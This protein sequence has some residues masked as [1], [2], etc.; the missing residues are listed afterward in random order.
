MKLLNLELYERI[1]VKDAIVPT[2]C[3]GSVVDMPML[4]SLSMSL[5]GIREL[6]PG[7]FRNLPQLRTLALSVNNITGIPAGVFN[8]LGL[9]SLY[10]SANAI[11]EIAP[12]A[13]DD[14][15]SLSKL[16][17]DNNNIH[18]ISGEWFRNTP[19]IEILA[20]N[21]NRISAVPPHAFKNLDLERNRVIIKLQKN[22]ISG[23]HERAFTGREYGLTLQLAHNQ[24]D[25]FSRQ[26]YDNVKNM[27][28][29]DLKAN[30]IGCISDEI[31]AL[32]VNSPVYVNIA[33]NPVSCECVPRFRLMSKRKKEFF[34]STTLQC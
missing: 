16:Y 27:R 25:R 13:F 21:L 28:V 5:L 14:M 7:A 23:V 30:Q 11:E 1:D 32:L 33:E 8:K 6:Q 15:P 22:R 9:K 12:D 2:L 26:L 3:E 19:N 29:I 10:L 18:Q 24:I 20:L 34:Y 17:L 4:K 31:L